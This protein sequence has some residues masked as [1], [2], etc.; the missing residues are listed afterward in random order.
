[1]NL[2]TQALDWMLAILIYAGGASAILTVLVICWAIC[3]VA[4]DYVKE[5]QWRNSPR[6]EE[7]KSRGE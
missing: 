7:R 2:A 1:M 4:A 3:V 6:W 5:R